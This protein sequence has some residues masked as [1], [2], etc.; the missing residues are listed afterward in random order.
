MYVFKEYNEANN[1]LKTFATKKEFLDFLDNLCKERGLELPK[2]SQA[3]MQCSETFLD[4]DGNAF[5]GLSISGFS[6]TGSRFLGFY[7]MIT[8]K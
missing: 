6:N 8:C 5:Q 4:S 1:S 7:N 2:E 3:L